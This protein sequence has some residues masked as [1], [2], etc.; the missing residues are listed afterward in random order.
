MK[1]ILT[2]HNGFIGGHYHRYLK[3][4]NISPIT[5]DK[6]SGQDLCD[7]NITNDLPDCDVVFHLAATNGTRLFYENPTDV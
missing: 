1:T 5:V 3:D 4:K 6:R 2:G 7:I